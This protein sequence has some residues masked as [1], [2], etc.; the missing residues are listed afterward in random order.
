MAMA[1]EVLQI[2]AGD[3]FSGR[4]VAAATTNLMHPRCVA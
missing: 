4:M 2:R 3:S 1:M